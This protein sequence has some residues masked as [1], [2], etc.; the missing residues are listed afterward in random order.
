[1]QL[2]VYWNSIQGRDNWFI[3]DPQCATQIPS[4]SDVTNAEVDFT[5]RIHK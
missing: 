1:L 2:D 5:S 3:M 4:Y